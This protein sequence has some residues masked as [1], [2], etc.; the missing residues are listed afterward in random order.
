M[1]NLNQ[2]MQLAQNKD[3]STKPAHPFICR[4][5]LNCSNLYCSLFHSTKSGLQRDM[6]VMMSVI[7]EIKDI[8]KKMVEQML[9]R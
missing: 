1:Q 6:Q 8:Q 4:Q 5:D 9:E 3:P 2:K 7:F